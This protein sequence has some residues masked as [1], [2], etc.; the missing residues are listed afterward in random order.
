MPANSKE[1]SI[2]TKASVVLGAAIATWLV[3]YCVA[4]SALEAGPAK[5]DVGGSRITEHVASDDPV[6]GR[7]E[8]MSEAEMKRFY[9]RCSDEGLERHLDTGEA[10]ACSIGYEI[11]LQKH[12]A[13]DFA[14]LL[15][16]SRAQRRGETR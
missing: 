2:G 8:R 16:W 13:G 5:S 11:L 1:W 3:C 4:V 15:A 6:R 7:L 10:M 9:S 14:R 12:F